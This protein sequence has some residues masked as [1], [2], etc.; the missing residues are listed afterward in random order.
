M[1]FNKLYLW[2]ALTLV[3]FICQSHKLSVFEWNIS[4]MSYSCY[5]LQKLKWTWFGFWWGLKS[6]ELL[7]TVWKILNIGSLVVG[8]FTK[9]F[10]WSSETYNI[11]IIFPHSPLSSQSVPRTQLLRAPLRLPSHISGPIRSPALK[12]TRK[13]KGPNILQLIIIVGNVE[14]IYP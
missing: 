7:I 8:H 12:I 9:I 2:S 13:S 14:T 3:I 1:T 6:L 4:L 5:S 10:P 11:N